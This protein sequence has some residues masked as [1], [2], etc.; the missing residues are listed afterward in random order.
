VVGQ[1]FDQLRSRGLQDDVLV[2]VTADHGEFL[3][4]HG[5]W[6][7]VHGL[8]EPV[9]AVPLIL[10]GPGIPRGVCS[11]AT[12][13]LIDVAPTVLDA[14]GVPQALWPLVH[15]RVLGQGDPDA[16]VMAEQYRPTLLH[17]ASEAPTGD[18]D[19]FAVRR[20]ALFDGDRELHVRGEDGHVT[21][22]QDLRQPDGMPAVPADAAVRALFELRDASGARW[23]A[24]TDGTAGP[25]LDAFSREALRALGYLGED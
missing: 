19:G 14:A 24:A 2:V 7:H 13:R 10:A 23:Q 4:E 16:P 18:L 6:G 8:Y 17:A 25:G 20:F 22:W 5:L 12:A 3:G 11:P 9:L 1:L 15:G 21:G